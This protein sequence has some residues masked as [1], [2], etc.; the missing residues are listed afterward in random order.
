MFVFFGYLFVYL[1]L[2]GVY[3][4]HWNITF[5]LPPSVIFH[6]YFT[7]LYQNV[8]C[9]TLLA[10]RSIFVYLAFFKSH[11]IYF[12]FTWLFLLVLGD[13]PIIWR[14]F[15]LC[16]S[17]LSK[18]Y[19]LILYEHIVLIFK[20]AICDKHSVLIFKM[21]ICEWHPHHTWWVRLLEHWWVY[22]ELDWLWRWTRS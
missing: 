21:A 1:N 16:T 20:M 18:W 8:F 6:F 22:S 15:F 9:F 7:R 4:T 17:P 2:V 12:L 13:Y 5:C 3:F 14:T 10:P 19:H 11:V